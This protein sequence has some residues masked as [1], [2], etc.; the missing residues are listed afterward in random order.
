MVEGAIV[1]PRLKKPSLDPND[2]NSYRPISNLSFVSK[3]IECMVAAWFSE[4]AEIHQLLSKRQLVYRAY[5]STKTAVT[6]VHNNLVRNV[7]KSGKVSVLV[8]LDLSSAFDTVNHKILLAVL[9]QR[10]GV[11]GLALDWYRLVL[12]Q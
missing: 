12:P 8:L 10:F 3:I 2:L 4:H 5:H 1:R 6:A 7:D 11:T 9:E